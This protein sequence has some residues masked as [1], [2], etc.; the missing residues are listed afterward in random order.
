MTTNIL[1]AINNIIN[2]NLYSIEQYKKLNYKIRINNNGELLENMIKDALCNHLHLEAHK[3]IELQNEYFSYLGNQNNPPD[4]I[5]KGGD[6]LE[7]KKIENREGAIALNSSFPKNKLYRNST[8][9]TNACKNCEDG[10]EEKD[11][12]YVIGRIDNLGLL[13]S[14]WFVYGDCYCAQNEVYYK[15]KHS[16]TNSIESMDIKLTDTNEIAKIKK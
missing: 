7:I 5:L 11:L 4:L 12:C 13:K 8:M 16:I 6:A 14:L 15:V 1:Y 3:R 10:W 9:I 2:N